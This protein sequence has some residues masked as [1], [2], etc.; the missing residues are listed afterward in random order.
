MMVGEFLINSVGI[1]VFVV[2][3]EFVGLNVAVGLIVLL[4]GGFCVVRLAVGV[5]YLR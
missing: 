1:R 3:L 2:L 5:C 4:P